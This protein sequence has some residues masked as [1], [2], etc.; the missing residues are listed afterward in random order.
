MAMNQTTFH[1]QAC[2]SEIIK[3]DMLFKSKQEHVKIYMEMA[4]MYCTLSNVDEACAR[5]PAAESLIGDIEELLADLCNV[6]NDQAFSSVEVTEYLKQGRIGLGIE[7]PENNKTPA[8]KRK[9]ARKSPAMIVRKFLE[10]QLDGT[11]DCMI[12]LLNMSM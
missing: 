11:E 10:T 1:N 5:I 8:K 6:M 7:K 12:F 9:I 4:K 3:C 2:D